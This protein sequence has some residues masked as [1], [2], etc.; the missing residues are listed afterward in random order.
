MNRVEQQNAMLK[1]SH[2]KVALRFDAGDIFVECEEIFRRNIGAD[3]V[4]R[5]NDNAAASHI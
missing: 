5:K 1:A 3:G 4:I 2:L